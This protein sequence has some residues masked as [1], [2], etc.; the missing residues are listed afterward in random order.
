MTS[1]DKELIARGDETEKFD[2]FGRKIGEIK[3]KD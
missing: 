3:Y 1:S 2:N